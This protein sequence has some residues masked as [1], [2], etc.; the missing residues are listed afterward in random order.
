VILLSRAQ[1]K[2][3]ASC[4]FSVEEMKESSSYLHL[5]TCNLQLKEKEEYFMGLAQ[6]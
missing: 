5:A 6:L 3:S 4:E 1:K 2:S